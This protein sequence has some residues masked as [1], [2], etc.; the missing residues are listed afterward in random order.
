MEKVDF[1]HNRAQVIAKA[2]TDPA[3]RQALIA[4]PQE[5]IAREFAIDIPA[6][7]EVTVLEDSAATIHLVL[8]DPAD[9]PDEEKAGPKAAILAKAWAEPA[10]KKALLAEPVAALDKTLCTS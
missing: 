8:V 3:Y 9:L 7:L 5:V 10:F 1:I 4:N 2:W 6:D